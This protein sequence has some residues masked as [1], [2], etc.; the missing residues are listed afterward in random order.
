MDLIVTRARSCRCE[1]GATSKGVLGRL[2]ARKTTGFAP[3][4]EAS[5]L[6]VVESVFRYWVVALAARGTDAKL[7]LH[8]RDEAIVIDAAE[9][10]ILGATRVLLGANHLGVCERSLVI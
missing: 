1:T 9:A 5:S 4:E 3:T 6:A 2:G 10:Q 7:A 8:A